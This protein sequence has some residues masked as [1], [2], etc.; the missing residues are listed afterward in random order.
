MLILGWNFI[1]GASAWDGMGTKGKVALVWFGL[2]WFAFV[3]IRDE[4][5]QHVNTRRS[6]PRFYNCHICQLDFR[7]L[8]RISLRLRPQHTQ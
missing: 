8:T 6:L 1:G 2:V 3:I 4:G 5:E 7:F